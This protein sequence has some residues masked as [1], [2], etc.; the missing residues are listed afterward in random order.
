MA[1]IESF[2]AHADACETA[3]ALILEEN[4]FLKGTG[5]APDE[6]LMQRKRAA[7]AN[8]T[9]TL[10]NLRSQNAG[11]ARTL[12]KEQRSALERTQQMVM[13]TLLVD[14]ENEQLLL[15]TT[16]APRPNAAPVRPPMSQ[17][18]RLYRM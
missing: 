4:R 7:L 12:T 17:V 2:N 14:R 16:V 15:K 13:K 1:F 8:L 5:R 3:H 11:A 10:E 18:Q 9:A 6:T